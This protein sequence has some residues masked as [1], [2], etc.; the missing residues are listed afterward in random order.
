MFP[1]APRRDQGARAMAY[2]IEVKDLS[3]RYVATVRVTAAPD[4]MG[5]TFGEV[6]PE[7][8]AEIVNAGTRP[9]GPA[10][11]IFHAYT[12]DSVDM[13]IGFPLVGPIPTSGRGAGRELGAT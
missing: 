11:G 2:E 1:E 3:D 6:L 4:E 12:E 9:E 5:A 13:E 7:V 8:D 10:F